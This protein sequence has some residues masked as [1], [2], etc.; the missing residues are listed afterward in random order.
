MRSS[1]RNRGLRPEYTPDPTPPQ[2]DASNF[3]Q[4]FQ[5]ETTLEEEE[6]LIREDENEKLQSNEDI[7]SN[8]NVDVVSARENAD[9]NLSSDDSTKSDSSDESIAVI[10]E[11]KDNKKSSEY[12]VNLSHQSYSHKIVMYSEKL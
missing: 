12:R 10:S 1:R 2:S 8:N 6:R 5:I 11:S 7:G 9:V 4:N 3:S